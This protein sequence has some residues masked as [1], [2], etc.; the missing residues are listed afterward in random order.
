MPVRFVISELIPHRNRPGTIIIRESRKRETE[1]EVNLIK[2][3]QNLR[4][5]L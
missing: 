1:M 2:S 5:K 4:Q 3:A